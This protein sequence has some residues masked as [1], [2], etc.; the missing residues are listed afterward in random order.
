MQ[1]YYTGTKEADL[2]FSDVGDV[3]TPGT[4]RMISLTSLT[5]DTIYT[6]TVAAINGAGEGDRS[7]AITQ[8]T[9]VACE[10]VNVLKSGRAV[11]AQLNH[12]PSLI[13]RLH[14]S[15]FSQT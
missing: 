3:F 5:P 6:I 11:A 9:D 1:I 7:T 8:R 14:F 15:A 4:G 10:C 13:P 12:K 2:D